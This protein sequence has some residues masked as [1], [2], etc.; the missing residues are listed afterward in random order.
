MSFIPAAQF[1][2]S[3]EAVLSCWQR[4]L[5]QG[6]ISIGLVEGIE[7]DR[8]PSLVGV[9]ITAWI[10]E[11]AVERLLQHHSDAGSVQLYREET[12]S[13]RWVMGTRQIVDAHAQCKLNL[14][15]VHFWPEPDPSNP[16][17][18]SFFVQAD[19]SFRELHDGFG[20]GRLCQEVAA[21]H[22]SMMEAAGMRI[23]RPATAAF[24]RALAMLTRE[25][26]RSDP[27]SLM[28]FLFLKPPGQLK[29]K[30]SQQR[31]LTLALRQLT[32]ATL[33]SAW[34]ARVNTFVSCGPACT[35]PYTPTQRLRTPAGK[36]SRRVNAAG[37][38]AAW[39]WNSSALIPKSCGPPGRRGESASRAR[40]LSAAIVRRA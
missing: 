19:A 39:R 30:P 29:L 26:A 15:I 4:W 31:M 36:C 37:R 3:R 5:Q 14:W 32:D 18:A 23:V 11:Y 33:P 1:G 7:G 40:R 12:A 38:S 10:T 35:T 20:V 13:E 6:A 16:D 9:G 22:V 25:D 34:I 2:C 17:F 28:S 21:A 27:G 24:P 8:P